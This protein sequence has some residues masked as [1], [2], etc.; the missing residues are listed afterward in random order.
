MTYSK[1]PGSRIYHA[2]RSGRFTLCDLITDRHTVFDEP[3]AKGRLCRQCEKHV[4]RIQD[5]AKR[6]AARAQEWAEKFG[7]GQPADES[8]R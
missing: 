1:L 2:V 8:R 7:S 5:G 6:R 4:K 3:P